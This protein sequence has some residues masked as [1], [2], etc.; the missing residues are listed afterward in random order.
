[1]KK[2]QIVAI[3]GGSFTVEPDN[4]RLER[5]VLALTGKKRI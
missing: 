2:P 3:G 5:Y 4:P 1:M